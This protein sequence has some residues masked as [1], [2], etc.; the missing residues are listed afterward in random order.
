MLVILFVMWVILFVVWVMNL[1]FM[2]YL[3]IASL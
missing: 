3:L 2:F 1:L